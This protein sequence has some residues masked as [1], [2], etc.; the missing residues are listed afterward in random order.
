MTRLILKTIIPLLAVVTLTGLT[1]FAQ[2][3]EFKKTVDFSSGGDLKVYSD[4]GS[5]HLTSWNQNQVEVVARIVR[6]EWAKS[7]FDQ[8]S[9]D[10]TKI[11]L[12]GDSRS[13]T[14]RANFDDVPS[15][16]SIISD[17]RSLPEVH[18]E[19]RAPRS[20]NLVLDVDRSKVEFRGVEGKL[21]VFSDRSSVTA[22]DIAGDL[23][24]KADRGPIKISGA[25]VKLDVHTDRSDVKMSATQITGDSKFEINRGDLELNVPRSQGMVVSANTGRRA[26][27]ESDFPVSM[28]TFGDD[29]VEGTINGGGPKVMIRTDRGKA[30]LKQE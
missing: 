25:R 7:D 18:F 23:R 15:R 6:P 28:Q 11:D 5:V 2:S 29:R 3:R 22:D 8:R 27:F 16:N 20:L 12:I 24:V 30:R 10:A 19:I 21:E 1:I 9:I 26:G 4:R 13:L 17:G 14:V